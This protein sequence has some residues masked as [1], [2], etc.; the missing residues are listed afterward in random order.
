MRSVGGTGMSE[1]N[2]SLYSEDKVLPH[3]FALFVNKGT[4]DKD[5][6]VDHKAA[7]GTCRDRRR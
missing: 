2:P 6:G 3:L 5:N 7:S 4:T 1:L